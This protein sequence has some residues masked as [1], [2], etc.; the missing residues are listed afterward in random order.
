MQ[1]SAKAEGVALFPA[2]LLEC[3]YFP[4]LQFLFLQNREIR[5]TDSIAHLLPKSPGQ[6]GQRQPRCRREVHGSSELREALGAGQGG[7]LM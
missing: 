5:Q 6:A 1:Y 7:K 2:P 4:G 3:Y